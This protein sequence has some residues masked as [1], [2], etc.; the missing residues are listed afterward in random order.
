ML[1]VFPPFS[2]L[3]TAKWDGADAFNALTNDDGIKYKF[4]FLLIACSLQL[5][6]SDS[7]VVPTPSDVGSMLAPCLYGRGFGSE[8]PFFDDMTHFRKRLI[9]ILTSEL[10]R[11]T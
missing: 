5:S 7:D 10:Q 4:H 11:I 2:L 1:P 9:E 8:R 6:S 3:F